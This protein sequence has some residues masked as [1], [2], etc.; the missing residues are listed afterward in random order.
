MPR[1]LRFALLLAVVAGL[2]VGGWFLYQRNQD[3]PQPGQPGGGGSREPNAPAGKLVVLVVFDQM[4]GDY[5]DRWAEAFGPDGFERMKAK[6]AWYSDCHLPYACSSTAPGHASISTGA[7]PSVHGIIENGWYEVK[8][9][10]RGLVYCVQPSRPFDLVPVV[11]ASAGK[12]SRGSEAGYSPEKLLSET[13]ADRLQAATGGKGRAV[14]LSIKDRTAVLMGGKKP[15]AAYCFDTRDGKFHTSGF[16]RD[17]PHAWV[18]E[19]NASPL[20]HSWA[21]KKWERFRADLD[22]DKLAGPDAAAGEAYGVGGQGR[23]FPHPFPQK[24][25]DKPKDY[26]GAVEASPAGH[27]LL[28]DLVKRAVVAEKLGGGEAADLLCVSFSSTDLIGHIWG[29]DS[30]EV[31]DIT[32]RSDKVVADLLKFLDETLGAERYTL[33]VTADHGVCPIPEQKRYPAQYPA[34]DRKAVME[35]LTPLA[36]ALDETFGKSPTGPAGWLE[37]N[38]A[39]AGEVWPWVYLNNTA[40]ADRKL[41]PAAVADYAAQWVGNRPYMLTAFTRNQIETNALPPMAPAAERDVRGAFEKVK[42]AYH[43]AR[44]GDFVAVTKPG[45]LVSAYPAGTGHG[46]PHDHD[47]HV[48]VLAVGHGVPAL[49]KRKERVSSLIVAPVLA[50]ALGIDAPAG[51]TAKVPAELAGRK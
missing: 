1:A 40:I 3:Q 16:Y 39:D 37:L 19:F 26:Y 8:P 35:V 49:G 18:E 31:L 20:A 48:P 24:S 46:S 12:P 5:L 50:A 30:W 38:P 4:R 42:L 51:A 23:V 33:V 25:A 10:N 22:Y 36:A 2:A 7:P 17:K 14:S 28:F 47:T 13:V 27:D 9:P 11:P 15:E 6:G 44:C 43:P 21:G 32:L 45:V 29:P 41:D 34:A